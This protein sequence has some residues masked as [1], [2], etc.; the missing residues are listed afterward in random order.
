V[1]SH[2]NLF[3]LEESQLAL[4]ETVDS[5]A[6]QDVARGGE[7]M[8][9]KKRGERIETNRIEEKGKCKARH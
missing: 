5:C 6:G 2:T 4:S 8:E 3:S 9:E 7:G 1:A